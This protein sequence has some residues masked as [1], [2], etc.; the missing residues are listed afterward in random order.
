MTRFTSTFTA[1]AG[2][3]S[4]IRTVLRLLGCSD[5][6]IEETAAAATAPKKEQTGITEGPASRMV[7]TT[8]QSK[9]IATIFHRKLT[10][11]WQS[12][13]ITAYKKIGAVPED[14]LAAVERYY[15]AHWPPKRDVNILRHDLLT[16][17]NNLAGEIG[18]AH[19]EKQKPK[20]SRPM[21]WNASN[22][23]P[24]DAEESE[25]VRQKTLQMIEERRKTAT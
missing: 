12:N 24:M 5:I 13:E 9:R 20:A 6:R 11:P 18:R 4:R 19:A 3:G 16:L 2:S 21:E 25:R 1:P 10:T 8:E 17:F 22:V 7:P 14:D 23:V 15:A